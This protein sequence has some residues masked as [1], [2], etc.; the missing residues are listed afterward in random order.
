VVTTGCTL[1][2]WLHPPG[3][4]C[5]YLLLRQPFLLDSPSYALALR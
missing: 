3:N 2:A 1:T 4:S 5:L